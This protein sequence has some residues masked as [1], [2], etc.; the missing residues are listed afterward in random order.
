MPSRDLD[1][2]S[3]DELLALRDQLRETRTDLQGRIVAKSRE[4]GVDPALSL[5]VAHTE[6][7]FNPEAVSDTGVKGIFQVTETTGRRFGQTRQNRTDPDVSIHAGVSELR[8][9]LDANRGNIRQAL[10]GY[11]DPKQANYA[12]LVLAQYPRYAQTVGQQPSPQ[13]APSVPLDQMPMEELLRLRDQLRGS[14]APRTPPPTLAQAPGAPAPAARTPAPGAPAPGAAPQEGTVPPPATATTSPGVDA[15][16][17]TVLTPQEERAFVKWKRQYAPRDSGADYDLRGAFKA[18]FTPDPQ[19]GHWPDTFKKPNHPTFSDQSRYAPYGRPGSWQG[20]T[21]I[22]PGAQPTPAGAPGVPAPTAP[23]PAPAPS[24]APEPEP[25]LPMAPTEPTVAG[26]A[27]TL[28]ETPADLVIDIEKRD[29]AS[30]MP[31]L[32]PEMEGMLQRPGE[33]ASRMA[34]PAIGATLGGM[35]GGIPGAILGGTAGY[36]FNVLTGREEFSPLGLVL[37]M[38]GPALAPAGQEIRG[39]LTRLSSAGRAVK[40]AET[41]TLQELMEYMQGFRQQRATTQATATAAA[42]KDAEALQRWQTGRQAQD[43]EFARKADKAVGERRTQDIEDFAK[44]EAK[45]QTEQREFALSAE[46]KVGDFQQRYAAWEQEQAVKLQRYADT[47]MEKQRAYGEAQLQAEAAFKEQSAAVYK[48][49]AAEARQRRV[50]YHEARAAQAKAVQAHE[51]GLRRA[52]ALPQRY[53]PPEASQTLYD[54]LARTHADTPITVT[55]A[56]EMADRV[57]GQLDLSLPSQQPARLQKVVTDIMEWDEQTPF[58]KVHQAL[59]DLRPLTLSDNGPTRG[60]AKQLRNGLFEALNNSAQAFPEASGARAQLLAANKAYGEEIAVKDLQRIVRTGGPVISY[61]G[62][63]LT[64]NPDAFVN[65]V[66]RHIADDPYF[67]KFVD[68]PAL[69]NDM[70]SFLDVPARPTKPVPL[71]GS[72]PVPEVR[73]QQVTPPTPTP[74][75]TVPEAPTLQLPERPVGTPPPP[76]GRPRLPDRPVGTPPPEPTAPPVQRVPF[77]PPAPVEP[78]LSWGSLGA[79]VGIGGGAL[80]ALSHVPGIGLAMKVGTTVLGVD[81][82]V[83]KLLL[84]PTYRPLLLRAMGPQGEIDPQVLGR[85]AALANA[86]PEMSRYIKETVPEERRKKVEGM[87]EDARQRMERR[88]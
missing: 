5:A 32:D 57:R 58:A 70:Q 28:T 9:L 86:V 67:A 39:G 22:P 79:R 6:S 35:L 33:E 27:R 74:L 59:K 38:G 30:R 43:L 19:S 26:G 49:K 34:A 71:P 62:G 23:A 48:A 81:A 15:K 7:L 18:G 42:A 29:P 1:Q 11:G 75:P 55:T 76:P 8:R 66:E 37:N 2:M 80:Y 77:E 21:F 41:Q 56:Q 44:W 25:A 12:D 82:L 84:S 16:F 45:R 20:E 40:A 61:K 50:D 78:E 87:I 13:T 68:V 24:V 52:Q 53:R 69:R 36:G 83:S 10:K 51:A 88:R 63:K 72:V 85:I 46:E 31:E 54:D 14:S 4:L 60:T 17:N 64:L 73:A 65:Q 47:T 3:T